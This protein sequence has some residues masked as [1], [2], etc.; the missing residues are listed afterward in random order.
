[1]K[2]NS[3]R[4]KDPANQ[5]GLCKRGCFQKRDLELLDKAA[6][7]LTTEDFLITVSC[8]LQTWAVDTLICVPTW[9]LFVFMGLYTADS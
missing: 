5:Y 1:M 3:E 6:K 9:K 7:Q 8:L 2:G 4:L